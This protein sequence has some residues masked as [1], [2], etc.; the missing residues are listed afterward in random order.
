MWSEAA[1]KQEKNKKFQLLSAALR[2][3][4]P[5]RKDPED[6]DTARLYIKHAGQ[7]L[8]GP[9]CA[10]CWFVFSGCTCGTSRSLFCT[11]GS[12]FLVYFLLPLKPLYAF[13]F[14]LDF[15]FLTSRLTDRVFKPPFFFG[16]MSPDHHHPF[17]IIFLCVHV[18]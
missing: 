2:A 5:G 3:A 7:V 1:R 10:W 14:H 4:Q 13:L 9:Q 15:Y 6:K 12:V 11:C 8:S 17:L 16:Q 18:S